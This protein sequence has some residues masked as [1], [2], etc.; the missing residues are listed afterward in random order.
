MDSGP[1]SG[2]HFS[3]YLL[4]DHQYANVTEREPICHRPF[5]VE[6]LYS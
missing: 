6:L 2:S 5:L 3:S 1:E 4:I